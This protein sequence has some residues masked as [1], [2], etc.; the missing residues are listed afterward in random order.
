MSKEDSKV[1]KFDHF[2]LEDAQDKRIDDYLM[3][4][5]T[6][7]NQNLKPSQQPEPP[8]KIKS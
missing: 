6:I 7:A 3:L 1:V 2:K 5:L 4:M 8:L